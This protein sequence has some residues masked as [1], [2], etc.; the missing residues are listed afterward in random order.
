MIQSAFTNSINDW[1]NE[2]QIAILQTQPEL[3]EI[4]K[5]YAAEAI[6]ARDLLD[7]NLKSLP[8]GAQIL[9]VGAGSLILSCQL[10][11]EGY[12][13]TAIEPVGQ[14]FSHFNELQN[15]I[16]KLASQG[17]FCPN[18]LQ[19]HA[20]DLDI[21]ETFDFAFSINVMEHVDNVS[22]V[23]QRVVG[24]LKSGAIYR[25]ICPNYSFPYEPH[26]NIPTIFSKKITGIIFKNKIYANANIPDPAGTWD[27]INWISVNLVRDIA[28]NNKS[29]VV[30]SKSLLLKMIERVLNDPIFSARRPS[31]LKL[32]FALVVKLHLHKLTQHIPPCF[33]P[34]MD[35]SIY[36]A[37]KV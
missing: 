30:F 2:I 7:S 3:C 34:I 25:F 28:F 12:E 19:I 8:E 9:E 20:E 31:W 15:V 36:S 22:Q 10:C 11:R 27:S 32:I 18:I 29:T 37:R 6:F 16:L 21:K 1:I 17:G 4:F 5:T 14:G 24:S 23:I 13:V 26:F 33:Q 35:C